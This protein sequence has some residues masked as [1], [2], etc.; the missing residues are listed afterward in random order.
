MGKD[1]VRARRSLAVIIETEDFRSMGRNF[2]LLWKKCPEV[3]HAAEYRCS[4]SKYVSALEIC[5]GANKPQL[6]LPTPKGKL[7]L[8][9]PRGTTQY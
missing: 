3:P 4:G 8:Y 5:S 7:L 1:N 2:H 9:F 6:S